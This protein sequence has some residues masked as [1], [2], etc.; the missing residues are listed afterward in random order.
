MLELLRPQEELVAAFGQA[1]LVR[2][3]A[4]RYELRGGTAEDRQKAGEWIS[5]FLHEA[6][7]V[8]RD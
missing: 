2:T 6:H 3:L 8:V 1:E 7:P 5:L 4:G